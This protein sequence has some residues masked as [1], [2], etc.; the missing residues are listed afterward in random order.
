MLRGTRAPHASCGKRRGDLSRGLS[1]D[2]PRSSLK[3]AVRTH[4]P[5]PQP[6]RTRVQQHKGRAARSSGLLLTYN[7]SAVAIIGAAALHCQ[8]NPR[9]ML[10]CLRDSP[11]EGKDTFSTAG[12]V[13]TAQSHTH[14]LLVFLL[15]QELQSI[16]VQRV[17]MVPLQS[18]AGSQEALLRRAEKSTGSGLCNTVFVQ[19][20][21][22]EIG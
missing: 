18:R 9:K 22:Q 19:H 13:G 1:G 11:A 17:A 4:L 8:D 16:P 2:T 12:R 20:F 14:V 21:K 3:L 5:L 15:F 10:L 6:E 7:Q